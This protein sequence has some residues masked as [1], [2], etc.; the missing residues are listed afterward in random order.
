VELCLFDPFWG[1]CPVAGLCNYQTNVLYAL[2]ALT[3]LDTLML[4]DEA[5]GLAQA[6]YLKKHMYYNMRIK[7]VRRNVASLL[8]TA[9][10]GRAAR[11]GPLAAAR[12]RLSHQ[13]G[14]LQR[15][16]DEAGE[17]RSGPGA[18]AAR[19]ALAPAAAHVEALTAMLEELSAAIEAR[20]APRPALPGLC[21]PPAARDSGTTRLTPGALLAAGCTPQA[22]SERFE[23]SR[24][25]TYALV[26]QR[27]AR[28]ILELESCGNV[29]LEE[30]RPGD[31]W[32]ASCAAMVAGRLHVEEWGEYRIKAVQARAP[33]AAG[34]AA[35][36]GAQ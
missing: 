1:E 29:R 6:T 16:L 13:R 4:A 17:Y 8:R 36:P 19:T 9:A 35:I 27:V 34:A 26:E 32:V 12:A 3:A 20:A 11:E 33:C 7:T 22:I 31:A 5:K 25:E 23:E 30:G 10:A 18:A 2:P 15:E 24:A 14:A 21:P 28:L